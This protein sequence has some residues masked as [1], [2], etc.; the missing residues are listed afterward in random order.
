[1][2]KNKCNRLLI[3]N[4]KNSKEMKFSFDK[5]IKKKIKLVNFTSNSK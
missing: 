1:M 3:Y 5:Y 2:K 4:A